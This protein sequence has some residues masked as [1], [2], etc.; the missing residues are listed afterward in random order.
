M[1]IWATSLAKSMYHEV[2]WKKNQSRS[3][4]QQPYLQYASFYKMPFLPHL[5]WNRSTKQCAKDRHPRRQLTSQHIIKI[6]VLGQGQETSLSTKI[7]VLLF[8]LSYR[9]FII[10]SKLVP[11]LPTI[12]LNPCF[13]APLPV[14]FSDIFSP[15]RTFWN[16]HVTVQIIT[17]PRSLLS[18]LRFTGFYILPYELKNVYTQALA[19]EQHDF[20]CFI[21]AHPS[22]V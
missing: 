13:S 19:N 11:K 4:R 5:T 17:T 16:A 8:N 15:T 6:W 22:P 10:S 3:T 9:N 2:Q 20:P 7:S 1:L 14:I 12:S 18:S 21:K